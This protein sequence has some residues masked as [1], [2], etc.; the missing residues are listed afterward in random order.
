MIS[1][2]VQS[3]NVSGVR[4]MFD[5]ASKVKD[6]ISLTI[7][8]P[9]FDVPSNVKEKAIEAIRQGKNKYI[10]TA[11][12]PELKKALLEKLSSKNG[13]KADMDS[14]IVTSA[15]SGALSIVFTALLQKGD[16]IIIPDPYFVA[17][18]QLALQ[19]EATPVFVDTKEDFS[20]DVDAI[21]KNI[22]KKTKAIIINTPN[23]PTGK[24]YTE[25]ELRELAKVA[26]KKGVI[27]I[28]DEVYEDFCFE[29]KHFSIGSIYSNTI[30]V[31]GFSKSHAMTGW[32]IGYCVGPKEVI[33]EA[34]KVQQFNFV[35]APTPFQYAAIEALKTDVSQ[36][37]K[38]Y[39]HRRDLVYSGLKDKYDIVK[40]EGAFYAFVKYPEGKKDLSRDVV[41]VPTDTG[42]K[43]I[44]KCIENSLLVVP[45]KTFSEKDTHFRIS[46]AASEEVLKKGIAVLNRVYD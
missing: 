41:I 45:G 18:K 4:K 30:T 20:L 29:K 3:M 21:K 32:R 17:Y 9:D 2:K 44:A 19:N 43:F 22:T 36:E 13:I 7:G 15:A 10:T 33:Q 37:L 12:L 27:I 28:S 5:M 38:A 39:K 40:P 14:I 25:E 24:V 31:N 34:I 16:E 23:N 26:G 46:F 35:C 11:G 1:K 8:E 6:P 42:E